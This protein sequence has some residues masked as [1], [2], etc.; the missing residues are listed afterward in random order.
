MGIA[1]YLGSAL[2]LAGLVCAVLPALP[3]IPLIFAG[4]W[5]VAAGDNYRH[6][7]KWWLI[8]I[9]AIGCVGLAADFLAAAL[10]AKR[11]NASKQAIWGAVIGTLVGL[12]FGIVGLLIGPFLGALVGELASGSSVTRSTDVGLSTWIGLI[13]GML[14]K[15]VASLMMVAMLLTAWFAGSIR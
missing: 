13:L 9:A 11:V 1:L 12:F 14:V 6:L 8:C 7:G 15:L 4:I 3:G 5:L 10:G 2:I